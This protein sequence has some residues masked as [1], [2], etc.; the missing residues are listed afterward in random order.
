M[1]IA[2]TKTTTRIP[3]HTPAL[4]ISPIIWQELNVSNTSKLINNNEDKF[5][6]FGNLSVYMQ[7]YCHGGSEL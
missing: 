7:K 6:I 2:I 1:I 5:F 4:K 3:T